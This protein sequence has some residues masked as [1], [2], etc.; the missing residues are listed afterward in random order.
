M[1]T[2]CTT[3]LPWLATHIPTQDKSFTTDNTGRMADLQVPGATQSGGTRASKRR[4]P[5]WANREDCVES[6]RRPGSGPPE[7]RA[8]ARGGDEAL[9]REGGRTLGAGRAAPGNQ[10]H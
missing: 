3:T 6:L 1:P 9:A 5:P 7:T 8:A 10:R 4:G 2:P